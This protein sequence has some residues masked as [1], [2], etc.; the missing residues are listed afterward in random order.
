L[1]GLKQD[2]KRLRKVENVRRVR[3]GIASKGGQ[4]S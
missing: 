2:V 1:T 4:N 3:G